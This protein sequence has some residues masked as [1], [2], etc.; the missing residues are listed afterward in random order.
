VLENIL[1]RLQAVDGSAHFLLAARDDLGHGL[2]ESRD[3]VSL[4]QRDHAPGSGDIR[5]VLRLNVPDHV[6]DADIGSN[7]AEDVTYRLAAVI[8]LGGEEADAFLKIVLHARNIL[9]T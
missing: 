3:P 8:E 6:G 7:D 2:L 9:R 4:R 1:A 5:V